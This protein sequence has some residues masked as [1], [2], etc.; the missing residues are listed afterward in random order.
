MKKIL[1]QIYEK[2]ALDIGIE[3]WYSRTR[4][5]PTNLV[6]INKPTL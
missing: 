1:Q 4:K 5:N 2:I 6:G 3:A